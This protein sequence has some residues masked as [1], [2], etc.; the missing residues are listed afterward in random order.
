[1]SPELIVILGV[2]IG[3]LTAMIALGALGVTLLGQ[4]ERRTALQ[5]AQLREEMDRRFN[6]F[7]GEMNRR[8][9]ETN[10]RF[11]QQ[12]SDTDCRFE[13]LFGEMNRRFDQLYG[14]MN[15]RFDQQK[16]EIDR[17][18]DQ[19]YEEMNRRFDAQ[20]ERIRGLEQGQAHLA[21]QFDAL[22]D[23]FTHQTG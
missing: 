10:R 21:G 16:G 18:F 9:D 2:G 17:R 11:D 13:E 19:L 14:E 8:F 5:I 23:Y 6:D 20:D 12:K 22:K 7:Y 1:M 4:S 15:R 3:L